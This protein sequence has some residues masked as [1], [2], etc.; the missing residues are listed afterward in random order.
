[1]SIPIFE[2]KKIMEQP[3]LALLIMLGKLNIIKLAAR[4]DMNAPSGL[5]VV[6]M[7]KKNDI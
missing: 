4:Y 5:G 1:M 7:D 2:V 6:L 3:N